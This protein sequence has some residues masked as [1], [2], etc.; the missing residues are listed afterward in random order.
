LLELAVFLGQFGIGSNVL[1]QVDDNFFIRAYPKLWRDEHC[2]FVIDRMLLLVWWWMNAKI[3]FF[4][5]SRA[6]FS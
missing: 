5:I 2:F 1:P 4:K 3:A 6:F